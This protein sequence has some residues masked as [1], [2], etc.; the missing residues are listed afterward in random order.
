M[1]GTP[2]AALIGQ[3]HTE[4]LDGLGNPAI[5]VGRE[6]AGSRAAGTPLQEHQQRQPVVHMLRGT[7]HAVEQAN[8]LSIESHAWL[9]AIPVEWHVDRILRHMESRNIVFIEQCHHTPSRHLNDAMPSISPTCTDKE[10]QSSHRPM[11]R[12]S[13]AYMLKIWENA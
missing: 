9:M 8:R 4:M 11:C 10:A 1:R 6:R 5:G 12:W 13:V 7:D 2:G 3:H